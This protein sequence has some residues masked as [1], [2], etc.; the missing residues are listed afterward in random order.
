[1]EVMNGLEKGVGECIHAEEACPYR[2]MLKFYA[3][4]ATRTRHCQT[5][6]SLGRPVP[7]QSHD[8]IS[9]LAY[10]AGMVAVSRLPKL[11]T[12]IVGQSLN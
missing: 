2:E 10:Y 1:M 6:H 11:G 12:K 3:P 5:S 8:F 7:I 4:F 9:L